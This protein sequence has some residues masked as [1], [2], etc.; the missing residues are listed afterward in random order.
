MSDK[1]D[2]N[3]CVLEDKDKF[4]KLLELLGLH[5]QQGQV[6]VF[7]NHQTFADTLL[8][9]CMSAGYPCLTLHGGLDQQ[10]RDSNLRDFK[11][12]NIPLLIATSVA[13]RGLDVRSLL[14]VV[15]YDCPNHYEDYVHR[16]G[17]TGRAGNHGTAWTFITPD[18]SRFAGDIIKAFEAQEL[19]KAPPE[20]RWRCFMKGA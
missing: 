19:K 9:E 3:A 4:H 16:V 7:V 13:A 2:Q 5:Q 1:V 20:V 10:D 11:Q 8:K 18:Q 14:L 6:L 12:G 15:N 17:R